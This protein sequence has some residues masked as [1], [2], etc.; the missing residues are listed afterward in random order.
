M[1]HA[2]SQYISSTEDGQEDAKCVVFL[3]WCPG[4][5]GDR[6]SPPR[7]QPLLLMVLGGWEEA[8]SGKESF[9]FLY[10]NNDLKL[11]CAL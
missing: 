5:Q 9:R 8:G 3:T 11:I 4:G 10:F 6:E 7:W 2:K 1:Q